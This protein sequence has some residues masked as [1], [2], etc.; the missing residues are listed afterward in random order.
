MCASSPSCSTPPSLTEIEVEDGDRKIRVAR[1]AARLP[2]RPQHYARAPAAP[3]RRATRGRSAEPCAAAAADRQC[4][5]IADGRHRLSGRPNPARPISSASARRSAGD[6]LLI[7]EAMKVMNP[8][9]A[10]TAG[11]VKAVLSRTASRS[12]STSRSSSSAESKHGHQEAPDRQPRRDRA[13]HPPRLRTKWASRRSRSIRPP[14]PTRCTSGSPT[15]R[16][17][18][19]RRGHRQ[20]S[21]HPNIISA[22]EITGADAIHPGYGFLSRKRAFAEIVEAHDMIFVGPEARAYPHHGR[23]GRGQA[24]RGR[25]RPA[26]RPRLGDGAVSDVDEGA[27]RSPRR[28]AIR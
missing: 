24:H 5:E 3:P 2:H 10:P 12:N 1:K 11:T 20:L 15:R 19:A 25:A 13:A 22:A 23:Q 18:S 8:I 14:M 17:A 27:R 26:A 16:S 9:V 7:I 6:T 28:S 21:Q 4:G